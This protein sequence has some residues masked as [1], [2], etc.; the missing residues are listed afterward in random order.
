MLQGANEW[1]TKSLS[2]A[3][4]SCEERVS[5]RKDAKHTFPRFSAPR[6]MPTSKK[7]LGGMVPGVP[8]LGVYGQSAEQPLGMVTSTVFE[9]PIASTGPVGSGV[10]SARVS[11]FSVGAGQATPPGQRPADPTHSNTLRVETDPPCVNSARMK[12][13]PLA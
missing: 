13:S 12:M 4:T 8:D 7:E 3:S 2:C 9:N 5:R 1:S 11:P 6:S 10:M